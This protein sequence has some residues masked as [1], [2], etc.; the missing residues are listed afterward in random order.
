[1]E[2]TSAAYKSER[3]ASKSAK[4]PKR[5]IAA[6][7]ISHLTGTS[8]Y[9]LDS[10]TDVWNRRKSSGYCFAL[11]CTAL[12]SGFRD[13]PARIS[14]RLRGFS[15]SLW[16]NML[17]PHQNYASTS[18]PSATASAISFDSTSSTSSPSSTGPRVVHWPLSS[19]YSSTGALLSVSPE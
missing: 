2:K 15:C 12:R 19:S 5:G 9:F 6:I 18:M 4:R 17:T 11:L 1:M 13:R 8:K 16:W 3:C 10:C 7:L 14:T